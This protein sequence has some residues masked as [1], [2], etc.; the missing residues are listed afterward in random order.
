LYERAFNW[1]G[2]FMSVVILKNL[3][4]VSIKATSSLAISS[5]KFGSAVSIMLSG[6]CLV[7]VPCSANPCLSLP[8]CFKTF[9]S[10]VLKNAFLREGV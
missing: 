4:R 10:S 8:V 6:E 3:L 7:S 9:M 1:F 5:L 2:S